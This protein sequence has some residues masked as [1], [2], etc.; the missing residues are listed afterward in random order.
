MHE[1]GQK[2]YP[3]VRKGLNTSVQK[4][5]RNREPSVHECFALNKAVS[6]RTYVR[7]NM[8][9][10]ISRVEF[11]L[12]NST[13]GTQPSYLWNVSSLEWNSTSGSDASGVDNFSLWSVAETQ[14]MST[15]VGAPPPH[16][17][18]LLSFYTVHVMCIYRSS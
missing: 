14:W 11:H 9:T 10:W 15:A 2:I 17:V 13:C 18:A 7:Y 3:S 12:W 8:C 5:V 16:Y 4:V 6:L 1:A